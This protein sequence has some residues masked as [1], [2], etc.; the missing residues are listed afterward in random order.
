VWS[1]FARASEVRAIHHARQLPA[2]D[3]VPCRLALVSD[4]HVGPTTPDALLERAFA[5]VR[6]AHPNV[7]LLG[8]DY[9][10]LEATSRGLAR[11]A[12]LVASVDCQTKLAVM[13][14]HDL[15]TRDDRIV[16]TLRNVGVTVLVNQTYRLPAP[17]TDVAVVGL[18]DPWTGHCDAPS[19]FAQLNGEAFRIVLCHSPDG[20]LHLSEHD[21]DIFLCGHTHGGQLATPWGPIVVSKGVLSRRLSGGLAQY[22]S[23]EVFVSRGIGGVEVPL[24]AWAPPDVMILDLVRAPLEGP[25]GTAR[26]APE[27]T[28]C[29]APTSSAAR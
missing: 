21:L 20:L 14:N 4:L 3:G 12:E 22:Q 29:R 25:E 10:F 13:G 1:L 16:E 24:R 28:T 8:G 7:L 27:G 5:T 2:G 6:S 18:D 11:V 17:W 15:W 19:A 9:V 26:R 23:K